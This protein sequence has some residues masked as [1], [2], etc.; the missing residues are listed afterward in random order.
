MKIRYSLYPIYRRDILQT[1]G[2]HYVLVKLDMVHANIECHSM[3]TACYVVLSTKEYSVHA[4][5]LVCFILARYV[6][7]SSIYGPQIFNTRFGNLSM[8]TA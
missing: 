7:P 5:W 1:P 3:D 8:Y 6:V 4:H 2:L